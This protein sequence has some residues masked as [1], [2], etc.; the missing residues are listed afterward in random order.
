MSLS[1]N[2]SFLL[3]VHLSPQSPAFLPLYVCVSLRNQS[4]IQTTTSLSPAYVKTLYKI[5]SECKAHVAS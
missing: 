3:S 2:L 4:H 1:I 5:K